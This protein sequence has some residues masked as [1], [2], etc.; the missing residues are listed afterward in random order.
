MVGVGR[1]E[2]RRVFKRNAEIGQVLQTEKLKCFD[3]SFL[4]KRCLESLEAVSTASAD[5]DRY[6][7]LII[8]TCKQP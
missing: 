2:G 3:S 6:V 5:K 7:I 8:L 1:G 4:K